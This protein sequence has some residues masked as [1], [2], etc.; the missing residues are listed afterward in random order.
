MKQ[1]RGPGL[2]FALVVMLSAHAIIQAFE[3]W[4]GLGLQ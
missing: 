4:L 2:F 1:K 3:R